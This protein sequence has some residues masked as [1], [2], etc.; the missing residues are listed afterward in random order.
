MK[1]ILVL[2][3][4]FI[5]LTTFGQKRQVGAVAST[6]TD[7]TTVSK[8]KY[9]PYVSVG[10]SISNGNSYET[11]EG[12]EAPFNETA[13]PSLEFGVTRDNLSVGLAVGR[14]TLRGLGA[15][16]D[17]IRNYYGELRVI[18][19]F[20]L[21]VVSANLIFGVGTYFD[22]NKGISTTKVFM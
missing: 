21:G 2:A 13:Y 18:P 4:L 11:N 9:V 7:T 12:T 20:K 10:L 16:D 5:S 3:I 15:S 14:G 6:Q 22:D 1:K 17:N 19:S 8:P